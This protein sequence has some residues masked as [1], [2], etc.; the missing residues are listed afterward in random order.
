M[1]KHSPPPTEVTQ[2]QNRTLRLTF[3]YEGHNV[4]LISQQSAEMI[5]PPSEPEPLQEGLSGFWYELQDENGQT[6]F[7]RVTY[8]PIRFETTVYSNE[9]EITMSMT[10]VDDPRGTFELLVP[11]IKEARTIVLFCSPLEPELASEPATELIR[12]EL[13]PESGGEE[14]R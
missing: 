7:Q 3:A 5:P 4:T 12:F 6:L 10:K 11:V 8:N 2:N 9:P 13:K 1:N 14:R